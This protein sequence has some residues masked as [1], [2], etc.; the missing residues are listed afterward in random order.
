MTARRLPTTFA[1]VA[2]VL[3][4]GIG[5][6]QSECRAQ[7]SPADLVKAVIRSE[8]N[9]GDV[10]ESHW[11][12]LLEKEVDGK[13][14]TREVVETKL[15]SLERLV[16]VEGTPLTDYQ[17]Q[18]EIERILRLSHSPEEQRKLEQNHLK[19]AAQ[20]NA[21][22]QMI[23]DAFLFEYAD[24]RD[25]LTK[26]IFTPNP[27]FQPSSREGR[28]L[29]EMAGEIW[30]DARHQRLVSMNGRLMNDVKFGGGLL[31]RLE[32]GGE[33]SVK[34]TEISPG[35]WE[36]VEIVVNMRGRALLFK[37]ISVQ[38]KELHSSFQPVPDDLS[39]SGAAG[40][41]L[42]ETLLAAKR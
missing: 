6:S 19:D 25:G 34:R 26:L 2:W 37:T 9:P 29:H 13:R 11:K 20:Y 10:S 1:S 31:G 17:Q 21:F 41:L 40:L 7:L 23:P 28:V 24:D 16:A 3:L 14:E 15:G 30:V 12:Y 5:F 42:K 38:Q 33:F 35:N 39:L 22:L 27:H 8:A 4:S 32:K 18:N 36:V